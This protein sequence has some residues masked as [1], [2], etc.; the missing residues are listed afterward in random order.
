[1]CARQ[2]DQRNAHYS[3][4]VCCPTD[5]VRSQRRCNLL[6][7]KFTGYRPACIVACGRRVTRSQR[8]VAASVRCRNFVSSDW[9][10]PLLVRPDRRGR[11][12]A[13]CRGGIVVGICRSVHAA[14]LH[15][16]GRLGPYGWNP[17]SA[18]FSGACMQARIPGGASAVPACVPDTRRCPLRSSHSHGRSLCHATVSRLAQVSPPN[19]R[20]TRASQSPHE[21]DSAPLHL[22]VVPQFDSSLSDSIIRLPR[23]KL[24][25]NAI[26]AEGKFCPRPAHMNLAEQAP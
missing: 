19:L 23:G 15:Q 26:N 3:N 24:G 14:P 16:P 9:V 6:N 13:L 1:M 5:R 2:S 25:R 11:C 8:G 10:P 18:L 12:E 4:F 20:R 21:L 7:P 17:C 22:R